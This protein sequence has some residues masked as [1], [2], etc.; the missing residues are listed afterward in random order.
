MITIQK[1]V[2]SDGREFLDRNEARE[3]EITI[4]AVSKLRTILN[5]SLATMRPEAVL[6][7]M[8]LQSVAVAD[9][10]RSHQRKIPRPKN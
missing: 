2:T 3:H 7:E 4:D 8:L 9:V 6:H 5:S 10:L 1:Y